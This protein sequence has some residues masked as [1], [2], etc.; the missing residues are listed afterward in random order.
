[1][2]RRTLAV[3]SRKRRDL[4]H[5]WQHRRTNDVSSRSMADTETHKQASEGKTSKFISVLAYLTDYQHFNFTL[6]AHFSWLCVFF[7]LHLQANSCHIFHVTYEGKVIK[8]IFVV[9]RMFFL[10]KTSPLSGLNVK[11]MR[12]LAR[13][14]I[15]LIL[16]SDE[17]YDL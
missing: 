11:Q 5:K 1:M 12:L 7:S 8:E 6:N 14:S 3:S 17:F 2:A 15:L 10:N 9:L 4:Q 13:N 16:Y